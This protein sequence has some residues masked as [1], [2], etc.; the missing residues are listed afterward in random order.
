MCSTGFQ[1]CKSG[2]V[3]INGYIMQLA[4]LSKWHQ[5]A[6]EPPTSQKGRSFRRIS[7]YLAYKEVSYESVFYTTY[8]LTASQQANPTNEGVAELSED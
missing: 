2:V 7:P 5:L 8:L 1:S 6:F 3:D 4:L